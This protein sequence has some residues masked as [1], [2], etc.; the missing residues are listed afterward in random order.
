MLLFFKNKTLTVKKKNVHCHWHIRTVNLKKYITIRIL[1]ADLGESSARAF[2]LT[3]QHPLK[4]KWNGPD[5]NIYF[6]LL[7]AFR[8]KMPEWEMFKV[9]TRAINDLTDFFC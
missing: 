2:G 4:G 9:Q 8:Y 3:S 1:I 5:Y 7:T 6:I